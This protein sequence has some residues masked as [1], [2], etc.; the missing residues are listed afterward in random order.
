MWHRPPL[1]L[2]LRI[3]GGLH[4][5]APKWT[6]QKRPRW[7]YAWVTVRWLCLSHHLPNLY[8][9]RRNLEK[10]EAGFEKQGGLQLCESWPQARWADLPGSS[11]QVVHHLIPH[12]HQPAAF[13]TYLCLWIPWGTCW[14][15]DWD[16]ASL[17]Q[18]LKFCVSNMLPGDTIAAGPW[19]SLG[20][21]PP[22]CVAPHWVTTWFLLDQQ[23]WH[24]LGTCWKCRFLSPHPR[25]TK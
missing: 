2:R 19:T 5:E 17:E 1:T 8:S 23:H 20:V 15:A 13:C 4:K 21:A 24:H 9:R 25:S 12:T 14:T 16:P 18:G 22:C 7:P 11:V 6:P 3:L 10:L